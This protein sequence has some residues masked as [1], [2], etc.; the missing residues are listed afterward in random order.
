MITRN[1]N[2]HLNA[3]KS[4]PLLI[5]V[6]QYDHDEQWIFT[7]YTDNGTKYIPSS[8][9][10]VGIKSDGNG[11]INTATVNASGQV[12]VNETEQ[13]TAAAGKALY[14]LQIDNGTHGTANF[15]VLVEPK[16]GDNATI[17]DSQISLVEQAIEASSH[18]LDYGSPLVASTVAGMNDQNRVYVY[19]GTETGYTAGNWYYYNGSAWV[20][21]GVYNAVAVQTDPDLDTAGMAADAKATGD[22]INDLKNTLTKNVYPIIGYTEIDL[23]ESETRGYYIG[24]TGAIGQTS[25]AYAYSAPIQVK[26]TKQYRF[27]ATG[28]TIISAICTCDDNGNNRT[29]VEIYPSNDVQTEFIYKPSADG[30]IVVCYNY[31]HPYTLTAMDAINTIQQDEYTLQSIAEEGTNILDVS[32]VQI[33]KVWNGSSNAARA[34]LFVTVLPNTDYFFDFPKNINLLTIDAVQKTN[35]ASGSSIKSTTII[36]GGTTHIKTE[37]TT[38]C[39]AIQWGKGSFT[40]T[41]SDFADYSPFVCKGLFRYTAVDKDLRYQQPWYGKKLVWLG[42]SIPAAGKYDIDNPN[43]YPIM[44]GE[45]LNATVYNEAVGSSALHCKDPARINANNPYGFLNNFEAVSRCITNSSEEMEWIIEHYN[46][47]NVFTQNVPASLS[48]DDKE[49]IRSCSWEVKLEKYFTAQTF[50]DAWIIDHG[51]NDIPSEYSEST[52]TD[53]SE[54]TGTQH[55]GYYHSG[56]FT[57]STASSYL[58]FDVSDELFVWI[59]GSIGSW[60]DIYDIYDSNGNNIGFKQNGGATTEYDRLKINVTNATTL[61][62][63]NVNHLISSVSVEKLTYP[64][65]N[66]L[67]SYN[68]AFDFIVNKILTYNPKARIIMIGEYENQKYPTIS[69]NQ[70]IASTR[71]EFPLYR[72]WENSGW[73]QMPILVNGEYVTVMNANITDNL[74]PH[75]D[76]SGHSLELIARDIAG[77]L[78]TIG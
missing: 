33:G 77:W 36:N 58:E 56:I 13:M 49:F 69:E 60:Y 39:I 1:F 24:V 21:G 17:S 6:N 4:I 8:G 14:E 34:T 19:T 42:T 11:I 7:L 64:M 54:M 26:K 57:S 65:Y 63:S 55:D 59:S 18:I 70:L 35:A 62:V 51:H 23:T 76:T 3:G 61:R 27:T 44:V 48:D 12:V 47:S 50:P 75:T 37:S 66:S 25:G 71:W 32:D 73:S 5:N 78:N 40:I 29:S 53:K 20:S 9:S 16:P 28:T 72:Q 68:G 67:Y 45:I 74:H 38:G 30:Y 43:S 52:Y 22:A 15:T 10:I 46:D 31:N 41:E 2:L